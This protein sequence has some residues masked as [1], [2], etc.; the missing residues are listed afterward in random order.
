VTNDISVRL[1]FLTKTK[2]P[3]SCADL[4]EHELIASKAN[5]LVL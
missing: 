2:K 3:K 5:C 1:V 4:S